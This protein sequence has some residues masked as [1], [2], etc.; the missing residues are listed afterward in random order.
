MRKM[1]SEQPKIDRESLQYNSQD[2]DQEQNMSVS[3][4]QNNAQN[5]HVV[6]INEKMDFSGKIS[7]VTYNGKNKKMLGEVSICLFFG[8]ENYIPVARTKSDENGNYTIEDLPPGF[9]TLSAQYG[10]MQTRTQY[11]KVLPGQNVHQTILL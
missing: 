2:L 7:G 1:D 6:V 8:H 10:E 9:Y 3:P 5:V 11:I 4:V